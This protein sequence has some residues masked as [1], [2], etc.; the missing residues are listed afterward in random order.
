MTIDIEK[1]LTEIEADNAC[2]ED[3]EYDPEF[4]A[5]EQAVQGKE[6]QSMGDAVIEA[7]PPNWREV[8]KQADKLLARTRDMRVYVNYLRALTQTQGIIGLADGL[9]LLRNATEKY[10]QAIHPQLDV[11]D[12]NDPTERINI[13]MTLC[14]FEIFLKP[15]HSVPLIESKVL[16]RFSLRDIQIANGSI[17]HTSED[18]SDLPSIT[19]I[20]GAFQDCDEDELK[21]LIQ[22]AAESLINLDQMEAFI[23]EQVGINDA[24]S[25]AEFRSILKEINA[26]YSGQAERLGLNESTDISEE[27]DESSQSTGQSGAEKVVKTVPPGINN[28]QDVIKAL[29]LSADYYTKKEPSSPIPLLLER[30]IRLVGKDFMAVL[31]DMAPNGVEQ[32]EFLRGSSSNNND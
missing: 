8:I 5:F 19:A 22:S 24:A 7:E 4:I 31:Q 3:L 25:F 21:T 17:A 28:N 2:G 15:L 30:V 26:V 11:D 20:D 12:D 16:G 10:W 18:N 9:Q 23:T 14:D 1:Y 13:L 27:A 29:N 6:E 32:A